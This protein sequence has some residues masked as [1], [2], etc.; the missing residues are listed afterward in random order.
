MNGPLELV[1]VACITVLK[2]NAVVL[3]YG[4]NLFVQGEEKAEISFAKGCRDRTWCCKYN[5]WSSIG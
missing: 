3:T 4:G 1:V 2:K 5:P